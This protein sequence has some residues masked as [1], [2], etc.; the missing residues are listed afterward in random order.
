MRKLL[1]LLCAATLAAGLGACGSPVDERLEGAWQTLIVSPGG[2]WVATM[3]IDPDGGYRI[4]YAGLPALPVELGTLEADTGVWHRMPDEGT[5]SEGRYTVVSADSIAFHGDSGT[6]IWHR[7]GSTPGAP[8][9]P[10]TLPT[11][12]TRTPES[13]S[14]PPADLNAYAADARAT[15]LAQHPDAVLTRVEARLL[16]GA[17]IGN[18][19]TSEGQASLTF[20]FCSPAAGT[21]F[22]IT[23]NAPATPTG[24][25][26]PADKCNPFNAIPEELPELATIVEQARGRGMS[27]GVPTGI[28]LRRGPVAELDR[29]ILAWRVFPPKYTSEP[30]QVIPF[31]QEEQTLRVV[32]ACALI[33]LQDAE[34]HMA[35]T[36][37]KK[38]ASYQYGDRQWA[39]AYGDEQRNSIRMQLRVDESEFRDRRGVLKQT[40]R[41]RLAEAVDIGD[42]AYFML[43]ASGFSS[44]TIL[45]G[46]TLL[47]LGVGGAE[48]TRAAT[49][50]LGRLAVQRLVSGAGVG[51][52]QTIAAQLVGRWVSDAYSQRHLLTVRDDHSVN[53]Q[54]ARNTPGVVATNPSDGAFQMVT[55]ANRRIVR[56][57]FL[58]DSPRSLNTFGELEAKWRKVSR[59]TLVHASLLSPLA[60][61]ASP[62]PSLPIA[63]DMFGI[64]ESV[65]RVKGVKALMLLEVNP[66]PPHRWVTVISGN[67][68]IQQGRSGF[69]RAILVMTDNLINEARQLDMAVNKREPVVAIQGDSFTSAWQDF[70]GTL[71]WRRIQ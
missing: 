5:E 35:R 27:D 4:D 63:P 9:G 17:A 49:L 69:D 12:P 65:G 50:A 55:R 64:W 15:A 40:S 62:W 52:Q 3:V 47:E 36:L 24:S 2:S 1:Q 22:S 29:T 8:P 59:P 54:I 71:E 33:T 41:N 58:F 56:G 38:P 26:Q 32:D 30:V 16:E 13:A 39:C 34:Q 23:P 20:T 6:L 70:R 14:W 48:D 45:V 43:P 44:L 28:T 18:L 61:D 11:G 42:E 21:S 60:A 25:A 53:L 68:R 19:V 10:L 67:G 37:V 7:L 66:S 31:A 51:T 57:D 46:D